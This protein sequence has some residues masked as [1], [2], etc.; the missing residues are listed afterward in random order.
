M[1]TSDIRIE[2]IT[3]W[4]DSAFVLFHQAL[5][6]AVVNETDVERE[7]NMNCRSEDCLQNFGQEMC[8]EEDGVKAK[9]K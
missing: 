5:L 2:K 7:C 9:H 4:G 8:V 1:K 6:D 3:Y